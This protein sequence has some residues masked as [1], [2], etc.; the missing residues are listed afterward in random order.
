MTKTVLAFAI[1]FS[2][3]L[4]KVQGNHNFIVDNVKIVSFI[5]QQISKH[6]PSEIKIYDISPEQPNNNQDY[7]TQL[8]AYLTQTSPSSLP[9]SYSVIS[10]V[11]YFRKVN[12]ALLSESYQRASSYNVTSTP[13][14][15]NIH[16]KS[17]LTLAYLYLHDAGKDLLDSDSFIFYLINSKT[18]HLQT[19]MTY[20]KTRDKLIPK[21]AILC[22]VP[23]HKNLSEPSIAQE[24]RGDGVIDEN[25][26]GFAHLCVNFLGL[27]S[28]DF[29]T[30]TLTIE[31]SQL[32]TPANNYSTF[33]NR[34]ERSSSMPLMV[35][36][37]SPSF[38]DTST[39]YDS[40]DKEPSS[41]TFP[42][43]S[44]V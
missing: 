1:D 21:P 34:R 33:L 19:L 25:L 35:T 6:Q 3:H 30:E 20:L 12:E 4:P 41:P 14:L 23:S 26:N 44:L 38:V 29:E 8:V 28:I 27:K 39:L 7:I 17:L 10:V 16:D 43:C 31:L 40:A 36:E 13:H 42:Q 18:E 11:D 24:I 15:Q 9:I 32:R 37:P 5:T 2:G 22:S